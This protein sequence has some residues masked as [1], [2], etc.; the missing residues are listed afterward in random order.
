MSGIGEI[1]VHYI[2]MLGQIIQTHDPRVEYGG[3]GVFGP[4]PEIH[5]CHVAAN[6]VG[7]VRR[8]VRVTV[9]L[10]HP[11]IGGERQQLYYWGP[12]FVSQGDETLVEEVLDYHQVERRMVVQNEVFHD[13]IV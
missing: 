10:R 3:Y 8:I 5:W 9:P 1:L 12:I 4:L 11:R 7:D 13:F 2:Q 6:E